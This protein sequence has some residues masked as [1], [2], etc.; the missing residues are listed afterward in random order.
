MLK[1]VLRYNKRRKI[2]NYLEV[3]MGA[4]IAIVVI[5]VAV[6]AY[7]AINKA[8]TSKGKTCPEC[9]EKFDSSCIV[10]ARVVRTVPGV[11]GRD[12]SDVDVSLKCKNCGKTHK[13]Q[14][15]VEGDKAE[16]CLDDEL[17]AYFD[18]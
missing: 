15:M 18:K 3:V 8:M 13:T 17:K 4:L 2:L 9:K 7:T 6:V 5:V 12:F 11:M 10:D 16:R 1:L 14:I